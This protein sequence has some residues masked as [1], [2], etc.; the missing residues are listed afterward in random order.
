[1]SEIRYQRLTRAHARSV[2]AVAVRTRTSLW[3]GED[4]LLCVDTNGYTESYKRFYFRDIQAVTIR[5]SARRNIYNAILVLPVVIC[6]VGLVITGL[7]G[8]NIAGIIAWSV[9]FALFGIP[10]V[11]NNVRGATCACQLRT[12]VQ[13]EDLPSLSR[14]RQTRKI[15]NKIRPRLAAAQGGELPA[16]TIVAR[17]RIL[18]A[19]PAGESAA[20]PVPDEPDVP[21]RLA[22]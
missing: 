10:L 9:F 8:K 18:A 19:V 1:M 6:F 22:P 17:M 13:I 3:L 21:P 20:N 16:E 5:E 14:V 7:E 15:L 11:V 4:H 2:F 12:A